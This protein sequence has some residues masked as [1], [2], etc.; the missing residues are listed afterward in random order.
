VSV[1]GTGGFTY[2]APVG[3]AG[4]AQ[5]LATFSDPPGAEPL[6]EYS[7][8]INWGDGSSSAGTITFDN[9]SG[10]FS[11][12][13]SHLYATRGTANGFFNISVTLSNGTALTRWS[14]AATITF[15]PL[16]ATGGF[17]YTANE[18][19]TPA[20]QVVATFI[21]PSLLWLPLWQSATINWGDGSS[22]LGRSAR[23]EPHWFQRN[24]QYKYTED[25]IR[26]PSP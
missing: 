13:G 12:T 2:T 22:S 6:N 19:Q 4:T 18:G 7:A 20:S 25:P 11:V 16:I 17:T 8:T 3:V 1:V 26:S 14:S 21:D 5:T 10:T 24:G 23:I 15:P 9:A